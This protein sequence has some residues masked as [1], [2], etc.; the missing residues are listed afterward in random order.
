MS[1]GSG[2]RPGV[3]AVRRGGVVTGRTAVRDARRGEVVRA[4]G[5]FIFHDKVGPRTLFGCRNGDVQRGKFRG[6]KGTF[7]TRDMKG[8]LFSCLML[9]AALR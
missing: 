4:L 5:V 2:T 3:C 7:R 9:D 1:R 8:C 6:G